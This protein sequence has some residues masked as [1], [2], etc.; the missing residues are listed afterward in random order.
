MTKLYQ[1]YAWL[2]GVIFLSLCGLGRLF[3]NQVPPL[4]W[5]DVEGPPLPATH[6]LS[7]TVYGESGLCLVPSCLRVTTVITDRPPEEIQRLYREELV[8]RGW[9]H[10]CAAAGGW[11]PCDARYTRVTSPPEEG[12]DIFTRD[13]MRQLAWHAL[14]VQIDY[15]FLGDWRVVR[16]VEPLPIF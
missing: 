9:Y 1:K 15:P 16:I 14:V 12:T 7:R 6:I 13:R 4:E 8:R 11:S 10:A 5:H 2:L 3:L